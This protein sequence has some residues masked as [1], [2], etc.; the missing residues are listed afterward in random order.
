MVRIK[1]GNIAIKRRKYVL[2]LT[3]GFRGSHSKL[4]RIANQQLSKGLRYSYNGRKQKKRLF[5]AL[6]IIKINAAT[7][8][9]GLTYS[10]FI[11]NLKKKKII[12]NR[13]LLSEIISLNL[14]VFDNIVF[15]SKS[16]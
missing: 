6:W 11:S 13:K 15:F 16:K 10:K 3:S 2:N 5:R 8:Y 4:F 9:H 14:S 1:R 12:I 7:R